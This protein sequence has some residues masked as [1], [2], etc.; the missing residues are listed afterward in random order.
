MSDEADTRKEVALT[1]WACWKGLGIGCVGP[2]AGDFHA[3]LLVLAVAILLA[4][5]ITAPVFTVLLQ[6]RRFRVTSS[7]V[8]GL[9]CSCFREIFRV[10]L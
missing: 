2:G 7:Q 8:T 1:A 6:A 4:S 5:Y 9:I 3:V 10:S